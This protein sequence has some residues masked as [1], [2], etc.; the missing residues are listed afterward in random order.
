MPKHIHKYI[1]YK[2]DL[3]T[4]LMCPECLKRMVLYSKVGRSVVDWDIG[5][6]GINSQLPKDQQFWIS[7]K[8]KIFLKKLADCKN[9]LNK[10]TIA[11]IEVEI[12]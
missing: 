12:K 1:A 7:D 11:R 4:Y 8:D 5:L 3:N 9:K 6:K 10:H 2:H